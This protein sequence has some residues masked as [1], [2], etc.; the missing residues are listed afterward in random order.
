M[1]YNTIKG[2]LGGGNVRPIGYQAGDMVKNEKG[3]I[4][5]LL[6]R[7]SGAGRRQRQYEQLVPQNMIPM[8]KSEK[9]MA[10]EERMKILE[11]M[12]REEGASL[13]KVQRYDMLLQRISGNTPEA[14]LGQGFQTGGVY[15]PGVSQAKYNVNLNRDVRT[16]QEELREEA[17][18]LEKKQPLLTRLVKL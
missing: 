15:R 6:G 3:I 13:E 17:E 1:N 14:Q 2:Y 7:L 12:D 16:A 5:S 8:G 9:D 18:R 4:S 11:L 10:T